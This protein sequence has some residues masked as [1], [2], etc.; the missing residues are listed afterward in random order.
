[1][2]TRFVVLLVLLLI[3]CK[4]DEERVYQDNYTCFIQAN[5]DSTTV[6]QALEGQWTWDYTASY[7]GNKGSKVSDSG[8]TVE[9]KA[10]GTVQ[11]YERGTLTESAKWT[12]G[13]HKSEYR[14]KTTPY[15]GLFD[16]RIAICEDRVEFNGAILDGF[17]NIFKKKM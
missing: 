5:W 4:K 12:V 8:V 14:L 9:F 16:G 7:W 3:G 17:T 11:V 2:R 1:M 10:D 6:A 13:I 15:V